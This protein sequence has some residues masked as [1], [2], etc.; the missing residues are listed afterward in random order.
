MA[1]QQQWRGQVLDFWLKGPT[2]KLI[3][4]AYL[5]WNPD[6][7]NELPP[8]FKKL[9]KEAQFEKFQDMVDVLPDGPT[10]ADIAAQLNLTLPGFAQAKVP[11]TQVKKKKAA[12]GKEVVIP[13]TPTTPEPSVQGNLPAPSET[14][15][16]VH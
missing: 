12:K 5:R 15:G 3:E 7:G 14:S 6:G 1:N 13:E 16:F 4:A 2:K 10:D 8:G 9:K 11:T